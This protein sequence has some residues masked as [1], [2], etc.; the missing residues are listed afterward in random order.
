MHA[1]IT[2]PTNRIGYSALPVGQLK[3]I[4]EAITLTTF[5]PF[6]LLY[7]QPTRKLD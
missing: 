1:L 3:T 6:S 4:Q 2:P 5:V 7:I